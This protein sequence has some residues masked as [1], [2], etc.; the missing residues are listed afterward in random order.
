MTKK[1][2]RPHKPK[3]FPPKEPPPNAAKRIE[4]LAALGHSAVGIA[5]GLNTSADT[6]RRWIDEHPEL[7][8]AIARGREAEEFALHNVLY[9]AAMKGNIVA[10]I[11]LTKAKFGWREG[12]QSETANK[13][14]ITFTLPAALNPEEFAKV[15]EHEQANTDKP[16]PTARIART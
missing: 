1:L 11:Y 3:G 13:V 9:R 15:I 2:S 16:V 5:R 6:L 14:S 7:G 4:S 12:D 8:E 10:A